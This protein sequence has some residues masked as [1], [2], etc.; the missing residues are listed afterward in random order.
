MHW[1]VGHSY[2]AQKV[3]VNV[4]DPSR[5][6][7]VSLREITGETLRPILKLA[8]SSEQEEFVAPNSV[9]IAEGCYADDAWLRGIYA[10]DT[11]VGFVMCSFKPDK[12][13]YYLWRYMI[14][15]RFQGM[16]FGFK[17]MELVIDVVR[18][19]P[20]ADSMILSYVRE[21]GGPR[22]FYARLGFV[23]TGEEHHGEWLMRLDF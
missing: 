4:G 18:K 15:H 14:D 20:D 7:I 19:Q 11:A 21:D 17:A 1:R 6:S 5:E 16:G 23:D 9:S 10:G 12:P 13:Q 2:I 3:E 8:V 22:D